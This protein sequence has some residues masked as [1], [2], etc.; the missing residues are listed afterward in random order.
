MLAIAMMA[1]QARAQGQKQVLA[2]GDLVFGE[3][4]RRIALQRRPADDIAV[5]VDGDR[6]D[7]VGVGQLFF[8]VLAAEGELVL[9]VGLSFLMDGCRGTVRMAA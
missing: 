8:T 6:A 9:V 2:Q 7:G 1:V 3:D 5:E 4:G